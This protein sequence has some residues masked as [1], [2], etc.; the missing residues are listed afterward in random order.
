MNITKRFSVSADG[1]RYIF[2]SSSYWDSTVVRR[3]RPFVLSSPEILP[4]SYKKFREAS[5]DWDKREFRDMFYLL[6]DING[7]AERVWKTRKHPS[8]GD[9]KKLID[10]V[11]RVEAKL[12]KLNWMKGSYP[13]SAK[14]IRDEINKEEA[15]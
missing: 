10:H 6:V 14:I 15:K 4:L 13:F 11:D 8:M 9:K 1:A 12:G 2:S 5:Q 7:I 3:I